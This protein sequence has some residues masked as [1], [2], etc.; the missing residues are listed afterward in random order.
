MPHTFG[1]ALPKYLEELKSPSDLKSHY[2]RLFKPKPWQQPISSL[3]SQCWFKNACFSQQ[4]NTVF[5]CEA[6]EMFSELLHRH[7]DDS[8]WTV[9]D[10]DHF[11]FKANSMDDFVFTVWTD[12][13][14]RLMLP[15]YPS[16][17]ILSE[18][19][20]NRAYLYVITL[21]PTIAWHDR[22]KDAVSYSKQVRPP[23][24]LALKCIELRWCMTTYIYAMN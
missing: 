7:G 3:M 12:I 24:H 23:L 22:S 18:G 11:K 4:C 21:N 1:A 16:A 17:T 2:L 10:Q 9:A 5:C 20:L 13:I 15:N 6:P 14:T 8:C 19:H